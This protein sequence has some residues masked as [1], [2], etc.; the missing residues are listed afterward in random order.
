MPYPLKIRILGGPIMSHQRIKIDLDGEYTFGDLYYYIRR[1]MPKI[2]SEEEASNNLA[3]TP[4]NYDLVF[5]DVQGGRAKALETCPL[6]MKVKDAQWICPALMLR[7]RDH[8][9]R[10]VIRSTQSERYFAPPAH[11]QQQQQSLNTSATFQ[12]NR[13]VS[14]AEAGMFDNVPLESS[15]MSSS[16]QQQRLQRVQSTYMWSDN[17]ERPGDARRNSAGGEEGLAPPPA[18]DSSQQLASATSSVFGGAT[19]PF[20]AINMSQGRLASGS[21]PTTP[22]G[23]GAPTSAL[24]RRLSPSPSVPEVD[25]HSGGGR[26]PTASELLGALVDQRASDNS[27]S[28]PFS[29]AHRAPQS[30]NRMDNTFDQYSSTRRRSSSPQQTYSPP[31]QPTGAPTMSSAWKK[32]KNVVSAAAP[33]RMQEF[34]LRIDD[35][36]SPG[37]LRKQ[38]SLT[39]NLRDLPTTALDTAPTYAH[40]GAAMSYRERLMALL[41]VYDPKALRKIDR[42]LAKSKGKEEQLLQLAVLK[43]GPEPKYSNVSRDGAFASLSGTWNDP[44]VVG[45]SLRRA[46]IGEETLKRATMTHA[47]SVIAIDEDGLI[48]YKSQ[49]R[50]LVEYLFTEYDFLTTTAVS[51]FLQRVQLAPKPLAMNLALHM[52]LYKHRRLD[53]ERA[54]QLRRRNVQ[55]QLFLELHEAHQETRAKMWFNI[56][57]MIERRR[58]EGTHLILRSSIPPQFFLGWLYLQRQERYEWETVLRHDLMRKQ[59]VWFHAFER[60]FMCEHETTLRRANLVSQRSQVHHLQ[61]FCYCDRERVRREA[62]M[63]DE[64]EARSILEQ[65]NVIARERHSR[66]I[67][68]CEVLEQLDR[69]CEEFAYTSTAFDAP[70]GMQRLAERLLRELYEMSEVESRMRV[71]ACISQRRAWIHFE[72]RYI[73]A[74]EDER[75][76]E[77][78]RARVDFLEKRKQQFEFGLIEADRRTLNIHFEMG[79]RWRILQRRWMGREQVVRNEHMRQWLRDKSDMLGQFLISGEDA[80]RRTLKRV[81]NTRGFD[82]QIRRMEGEDE[83]EGRWFHI[84][85]ESATFRHYQRQYLYFKETTAR[86]DIQLWGL[87][88]QFWILES[89]RRGDI[90]IKE[91]EHIMLIS[92][93]GRGSMEAVRRQSIMLAGM[94]GLFQLFQDQVFAHEDFM[95]TRLIPFEVDARRRIFRRALYDIEDSSRRMI[96]YAQEWRERETLTRWHYYQTES[97]R[98]VFVFAQHELYMRYQLLGKALVRHREQRDRVEDIREPFDRGEVAVHERLEREVLEIRQL[99]GLE[100][101]RRK[102]LYKQEKNELRLPLYRAQKQDHDFV[103]RGELEEEEADRRIY[104]HMF[105]LFTWERIPR[106]QIQY[107]FERQ[108]RSLMERKCIVGVESLTRHRIQEVDQQR[109]FHIIQQ[110]QVVDRERIFRRLGVEAQFQRHMQS[111]EREMFESSQELARM[112]VVD[113]YNTTSHVFE[114]RALQLYY[115]VVRSTVRQDEY[116]ARK[117]VERERLVDEEESSR[118]KLRNS[119]LASL[120]KWWQKT[121]LQAR[122]DAVTYANK[123]QRED[124]NRAAREN[125]QKRIEERVAARAAEKLRASVEAKR[126]QIFGIITGDE[127]QTRSELWEQERT[128]KLAL[129]HQLAEA[130]HETKEMHS[131]NVKS[132]QKALRLVQ[133]LSKIVKTA[134]ALEQFIAMLPPMP[135]RRTKTSANDDNTTSGDETS[136]A[137]VREEMLGAELEEMASNLLADPEGGDEG[138]GFGTWEGAEESQGNFTRGMSMVLPSLLAR[139]GSTSLP[140]GQPI[141]SGSS[142][143]R[144]QGQHSKGFALSSPATDTTPSELYEMSPSAR[145]GISELRGTPGSNALLPRLRGSSVSFTPASP[146][147]SISH[148]RLQ[149]SDNTPPS[150]KPRGVSAMSDEDD[151]DRVFLPPI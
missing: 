116:V 55:R 61:R 68:S 121:N 25:S 120:Q 114:Q 44:A 75:R 36:S 57:C 32:L 103:E 87:A 133:G 22:Q 34:E 135:K 125:A 38:S 119:A 28:A 53:V 130:M 88:L 1:Q 128:T 52:Q 15:V 102:L 139:T 69:R 4:E 30:P 123:V 97:L 56:S 43:Y 82:V 107:G 59:L 131:I 111:T 127:Y 96:T 8:A 143:V 145:P 48:S 98:R 12:T 72:Q 112:M 66:I 67:H 35:G 50:D 146:A 90:E 106:L 29:S 118:R 81:M 31:P 60:A 42:I 129:L 40:D 33:T 54:D 49:F 108:A 3:I 45:T 109:L 115:F 21:F 10:S 6:G 41:A 64:F 117:Y 47:N 141:P 137:R 100:D 77:L 14:F 86:R 94:R 92:S 150:V 58:F 5:V 7:V 80:S 62:R 99:V 122:Q 23:G 148:V 16:S 78:E 147:A 70:L 20:A 113:R 73:L 136:G 74:T 24:Q 144:H 91:Q 2:L 51:L 37:L 13:S 126:N 134:P 83:P 95:R 79:C 46:S 19:D 101:T 151:D 105:Q 142:P 27:T 17:V 39:A 93:G 76:Q 9:I 18:R 138:G 84:F 140:D 11:Q 65:W 63:S 26:T 71:V 149:V 132:K 110:R 124:D 85:G 104:W 89:K